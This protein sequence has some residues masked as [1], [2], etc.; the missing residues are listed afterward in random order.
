M[1]LLGAVATVLLIACANLTT[2]LLARPERGNANS[3]FVSPWA[4]AG[5]NS[6]GK[7]FRKR[8]ACAGRRDGW[9]RPG[10]LGLDLLRSI[11]TQNVPRLAGGQSRSARSLRH[12]RDCC[13]H[14]NCDRPDSSPCQRPKPE[15]TEALKEGGRGS[16]T[17]LRRNR[18]RNSLVIAEVAL[19]LVLLVGAGLLMK[20]FI[21]LQNVNPGFESRNVLTMEVSL[22]LTKYP[23][24]K[25]SRFLM[26]NRLGGLRRCREW[27]RRPSPAFCRSA[28]TNSDSSF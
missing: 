10:Y 1:I 20:S 3:R 2:M 27:K 16:T 14:W 28:G 15:L 23:R 8:S 6:L 12:P 21:R 11:G 25:R 24:G 7:C 17:G 18:L 22:P 26:P 13:R 9:R 5:F 4:L 19:A